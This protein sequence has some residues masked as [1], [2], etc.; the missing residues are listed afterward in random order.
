MPTVTEDE[1]SG[2]TAAVARRWQAI[3]PLLPSWRSPAPAAG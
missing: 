3:D 2:L 1:T